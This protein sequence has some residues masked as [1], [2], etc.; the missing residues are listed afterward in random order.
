MRHDGTVP[1][2]RSL[3]V[4]P[5]PTRL[6]DKRRRIYDRL[7][8]NAKEAEMVAEAARMNVAERLLG[9]TVVP[10]RT[11]GRWRRKQAGSSGRNSDTRTALVSP[12]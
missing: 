12:A 7:C 1:R 10:R 4:R 6:K 8:A 2:E 9:G 5:V 11:N 3:R